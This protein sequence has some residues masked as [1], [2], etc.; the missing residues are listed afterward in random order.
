MSQKIFCHHQIGVHQHSLAQPLTRCP[1]TGAC[2]VSDMIK[3][4]ENTT[5]AW[6]S[7][8]KSA[9]STDVQCHPSLADS[10]LKILFFRSS[11][12]IL[13]F[14]SRSSEL[15]IY[16]RRT[17]HDVGKLR[18]IHPV[19]RRF[20]RISRLSYVSLGGHVDKIRYIG[21]QIQCQNGEPHDC[22]DE[23]AHLNPSD[24]IYIIGF[25]EN[26]KLA[27]DAISKDKSASASLFYFS[28]AR[29]QLLYKMLVFELE[30]EILNNTDRLAVRRDTLPPTPR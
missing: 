9:K 29:L 10:T 5:T 1:W 7:R 12:L 25:L 19:N 30:A 11:G 22:A 20:S 26:F 17:G 2:A 23:A 15:K 6:W 3:M 28:W 24:P 4:I 16:K 13:R 27:C 8:A 18:V 14:C 21:F